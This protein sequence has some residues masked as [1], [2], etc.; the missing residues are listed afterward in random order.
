[1]DKSSETTKGDQGEKD[2]TKVEI[3]CVLKDIRA[4]LLLA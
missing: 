2:W 3:L 4:D 1:M